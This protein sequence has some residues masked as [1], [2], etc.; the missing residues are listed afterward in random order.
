MHTSDTHG[1][2]VTSISSAWLIVS[3][4]NWIFKTLLTISH[5]KIIPR[6]LCTK[7]TS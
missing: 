4:G 2:H 1:V 3:N 6:I 5:Y 7:L